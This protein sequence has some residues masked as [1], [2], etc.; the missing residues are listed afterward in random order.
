[1]SGIIAVKVVVYGN[2]V[3][4]AIGLNHQVVAGAG[5]GHIGGG[6]PLKTQ[7]IGLSGRFG[8]IRHGIPAMAFGKDIGIRYPAPSIQR[9]IAGTAD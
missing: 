8:I 6:G 2:L 9:V 7:G 5:E 1:M 3:F 4:T